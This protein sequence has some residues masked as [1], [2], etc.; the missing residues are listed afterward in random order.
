M[1][2]QIAPGY[3]V[4]SIFAL[5]ARITA[6]EHQISAATEALTVLAKRLEGPSAE[7]E[8]ETTA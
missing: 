4:P 6:L 3:G 2:R 1:T 7:A 8:L 5:E